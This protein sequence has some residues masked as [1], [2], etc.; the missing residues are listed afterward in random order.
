MD[1]SSGEVH[2]PVVGHPSR[3]VDWLTD[4]VAPMLAKSC[5]GNPYREGWSYEVKWDGIRAL[6]AVDEGQVRIR[7]RSQ[8]DITHCFPE[9]PSRWLARLLEG[10]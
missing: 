3:R 1:S 6:I 2:L 4:P 10:E 7:S 9:L 5:S 8:R